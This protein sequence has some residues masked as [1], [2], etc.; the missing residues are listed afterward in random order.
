MIEVTQEQAIAYTEV[1]EVLKHISK[2]DF[3]KIPSKLINYYNLNK[4]ENYNF[5]IDESKS[6]SEQKLSKKAKVILAILFRDYW[7][8]D[9]QRKKIKQKEAYDIMQIEKEKSEKYNPDNLFK[10]N[11]N[12]NNPVPNSQAIIE[13]KKPKWYQKIWM[14]LTGKFKK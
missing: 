6:F 8:T 13:Y 2:Q 7:A 11:N 10:E 12:N 14:V 5:F 9:E 1:L 3:E 4:A